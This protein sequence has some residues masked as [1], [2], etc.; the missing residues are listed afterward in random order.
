MKRQLLLGSALSLLMA[1]APAAWANARL[2]SE[3]S[4]NPVDRQASALLLAQE[5]AAPTEEELLPKNKQP[6]AAEPESPPAAEPEPQPEPE[7][8]PQ[9]EPEAAPEPQAEPAPAPEPQAEPAP[10]PQPEAVPEPEAQPEA[11]PAEPEAQPEPAPEPQAKPAPES[12]PEAAPEQPAAAPESQQQ[13]QQTAPEPELQPK[14]EEPVQQPEAQPEPA[15]EPAP[16]PEAEP[17]APAEQEV[18]GAAPA[19]PAPQAEPEQAPPAAAPEPEAQPAEPAPESQP[20]EP[21][22]APETA[23][24][25]PAPE[26]APDQPA[27]VPQDGTGGEAQPATPP[28]GEQQGESPVPPDSGTAEQLPENAAPVLDSAKETAPAS[29]EGGAQQAQPEPAEPAAPPPADDRAAQEQAQPAEI[30]AVTAEQGE[31]LAEPPPPI[32]E[33]RPEGVEVVREIEDRVVIEINNTIIVESSDRPRLTRNAREVYYEDLPRRRTRETVIRED[34]TQVITIRNRY[35]DIVRRSRI[36]PDGHEYVLVYVD[37]RDYERLDDWRDPGLDLPPMRLD[38]PVSEYI[39]V[40]DEVQDPDAYYE[41]LERPPVERVERLYSVNE[42]KRS[43]RIRDKVPRIELD[44]VT[45]EFGS[46][47]IAEDQVPRLEGVAQAIE[48]LL[49]KNPAETFLIEG[50]T[51]AVGSDVANLALSDRRAESVA[52]ALTNVFGIAPENLATQGYGERYLKIKTDEQERLNR[53]VAIRRITPLVAP[54]ASAN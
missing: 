24:T 23:P 44:T 14:A 28:A 13:E 52:E 11:A 34:S 6:E 50:H 9:P 18:P 51:D 2:L 39:L 4:E 7:A 47:E 37:D 5:E 26:A 22:P 19:E 35:G 42:V 1:A 31:R 33:L 12:Q 38:V 32:V 45:F 27:T 49:K 3:T 17:Q 29:G 15:P 46:A 54:V 40:A 10:E 36:T 53:R 48:R 8:Q 25:E 21:A 20:A 43:A 41:F 30:Q 16:A